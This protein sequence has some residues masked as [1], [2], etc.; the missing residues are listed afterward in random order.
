MGAQGFFSSQACFPPPVL[1]KLG[2][3]AIQMTLLHALSLV[4]LSLGCPSALAGESNVYDKPM[5][6]CGADNTDGCTYSPDDSGAHQVCVTALPQGFSSATGQGPWSDQFTGEPW[7]ICIWAYSN[8]IL[9]DNKLPLKCESIPS[10]VLEDEYSLDK[11]RQCGS[12]SST[13]GCG[14]ED[15]RRSIQSLCEQCDQQAPDDAAKS[16]LKSKCDAILSSAPAAP[17]S[18]LYSSNDALQFK[19][20][21]PSRSMGGSLTL[22]SCLVG[23]AFAALSVGMV[24]RSL[25]GGP[26]RQSGEQQGDH[27]LEEQAAE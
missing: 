12:M 17:M 19:G 20:E 14:P 4:L 2:N 13:E 18:R 21:S 8:Y 5:T 9:Q 7:C 23:V 27:F 16:S 11:F 22:A 1:D 26:Y 24:V 3:L 25:R 15:I 6:D 10:K